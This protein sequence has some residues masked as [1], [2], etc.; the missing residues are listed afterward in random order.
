MTHKNSS[1]WLL[2]VSL[3]LAVP[4]LWT[5]H[6]ILAADDAADTQEPAKP[7]N[8]IYKA[9]E[10]VKVKWGSSWWDAT[11]VSNQGGGKYI[12]RWSQG[13][14]PTEVKSVS[15]IK[16][17]DEPEDDAEPRTRPKKREKAAEPEASAPAGNKVGD[18]ITYKVGEKT[19][20]G[21]I[22]TVVSAN[23]VKAV[24]EGEE[25]EKVVL[26][27]N[28]L[29][30]AK[31][32]AP[33]A[34]PKGQAKPGSNTSGFYVRGDE[35]E[36]G[37]GDRKAT[38]IRDRGATVLV[39]DATFKSIKELKRSEISTAPSLDKLD[40]AFA[41]MVF[42]NPVLIPP[43]W[44]TQAPSA[45]RYV[46]G[47]AT[48][49]TQPP[50]TRIKIEN[51]KSAG[52]GN[53]PADKLF[54]CPAN[55]IG[56]VTFQSG[57]GKPGHMI[58]YDLAAGKPAKTWEFAESQQVIDVAP[59]GTR[60]ITLAKGKL[61]VWSI[62]EKDP[63]K[64]LSFEAFGPGSEFVPDSDQAYLVGDSFLMTVAGDGTEAA[65][66]RVGTDNLTC[67]W[68][69]TPPD[70]G[71]KR[72]IELALT[73]Q[74]TSFAFFGWSS[75]DVI[76]NIS[77]KTF[78]NNASVPFSGR[79]AYSTDGKRL[80]IYTSGRGLCIC[81]AADRNID[82]TI[83]LPDGSV[84]PTDG[85]T[86]LQWIGPANILI[87]N[88]FLLNVK[89]GLI[90][91]EFSDVM[92]FAS[93]GSGIA[94]A[95]KTDAK[96]AQT[97]ASTYVLDAAVTSAIEDA[98]PAKNSILKEG[99]AVAIEVGALEGGP[100]GIGERAR[101]GFEN[102]FKEKKINVDANS[103]IKLKISGTAQE[104]KDLKVREGINESKV[105][106]R[107]SNY[108]V[109]LIKNGKA[110]WASHGG[111]RGPGFTIVREEGQTYQQVVDKGIQEAYRWL[112]K[113]SLPIPLLKSI[114]ETPPPTSP[115]FP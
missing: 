85:P 1:I 59:A 34:A 94:W 88:R 18:T 81:N 23:I 29:T 108:K 84:S 39:R 93:T 109:E 5:P 49:D 101:Q 30:T 53:R 37:H 51:P 11:I 15:E 110:V 62:D 64:T 41:R 52:S 103:P 14:W 20:T 55:P 17:P 54:V 98:S 112:E 97:L 24:A 79:S 115:L 42:Q 45:T 104:P 32:S 7:K 16:R 60:A 10:K 95:L 107:T 91:W 36:Y 47:A 4:L 35:I 48:L 61:T 78:W 44:G 74:R 50:N 114:K 58:Q 99:D 40:P 12:I 86:S 113:P 100:S 38:V 67:V 92:P 31:A 6:Q 87:D 28:I 89:S 22:T 43:A 46:P 76:D 82:K 90:V 96:G 69:A 80:A 25:E 72:N 13:N 77:G 33:A 2:S 105:T 70:H 8:P 102:F 111:Y 65:L 73:P 57:D 71:P 68:I 75:F 66:W 19:V 27:K 26:V 63:V 56:F 106:Y 83:S 21:T 3:A 9:G